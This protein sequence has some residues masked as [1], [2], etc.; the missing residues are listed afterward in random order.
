[1]TTSAHLAASA[2]DSTAKLAASAFLA[3]GRTGPQRDLDLGHA[4]VAQILRV[5]VALAAIAD[6]D[7]LL[8]LD[9]VHVGIAVIIDAHGSFLCFAA[10][11]RPRKAAF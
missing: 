7:H 2:G 5:G 11:V 8:A 4:A 6:D 3:R 10:A 9:Q 1:M